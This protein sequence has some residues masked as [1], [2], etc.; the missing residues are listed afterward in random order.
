MKEQLKVVHLIFSFTVGGAEHLVADLANQQI[1]KHKVWIFIINDL[2]D[3]VALNRVDKRVKMVFLKR[4]PGSFSPLKVLKLTFKLNKLNPDIIHCH[5]INCIRLLALVKAKKI[6]TIHDVG[7]PIAGLD[8]YDKL[9]AISDAVRQDIA[10]RSGNNLA[11]VLIN[12][13]VPVNDIKFK[14]PQK[15]D[16]FNIIQIS[17]L[18]HNK[19]GQDVAIGALSVLRD[20]GVNNVKLTFVGEGPSL[21]YLQQLVKQ[22]NLVDLVDFA[23]LKSR[24]WIYAN[25]CNYDLLIQPSRFE[26]FGLTVIEGM[27]AKTP[28]LVSNI[29]GPLALIEKGKYG[30]SFQSENAESCAIAIQSIMDLSLSQLIKL[31]EDAYLYAKDNYAIEVMANSYVENYYKVISH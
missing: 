3:E 21:E 1:K 8:K 30:F 20:K 27:A 25:L 29:D 16:W 18:Q 31:T 7:F 26:G 13:G 12:N 6:L 2:V 23:G 19:K 14:N 9:F 17:R 15:S 10:Q 22:H 4:K 24:E 5:T 28:C 11:P